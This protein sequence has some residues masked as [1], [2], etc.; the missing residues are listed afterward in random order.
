MN[1]WIA[2]I[3]LV[4]GFIILIRAFGLMEKSKRVF[5]LSA[6]S[7]QAIRNSD[8]SDEKKE[9]ILQKNAVQLFR[10]FFIIAFGGAAAILIPSS[11]VWLCDR[12]GWV[13]FSDVLAITLS[14]LF[15]IIS[16]LFLAVTLIFGLKR[17]HEKVRYSSMERILH[18]LAFNTY[19]AQV[20]LADIEDQL[21]SKK[22]NGC[23]IAKPVFVT[24]LPRAGTTFIL[25]CCAGLPEF[26]SH[27][28]RD[29]PFVLIPCLWNRFSSAFRKSGE[30]QERAHGDGIMINF[31]S[32]EAFE[33]VLWRTFWRRHYLK[34]RI[35]PW[36]DE[37]DPD[38]KAF[39]RSHMRKISL[40]RRED[41]AVHSRYLSKNNMNIARTRIL[42]QLFQDSIILV[43]FRKPLQHA[44]SMVRQHKNFLKIHKEDP[45]A[46]QYMKAIGHY[47]FGKNLRPIDFDG[48]LDKRL[49]EDTGSLAFWLEYWV[50]SYRHLLERS[51]DSLSF[52]NYDGLCENP[53]KGLRTLSDII[54]VQ[55]RNALMDRASRVRA[56]KPHEVDMG[57]IRSS[58]LEEADHIYSRLNKAVIR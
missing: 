6:D 24:A 33:E 30:L 36:N 21:F 4:I 17:S 9:S 10:L 12:L 56:P 26:A 45:F 40:L 55:D 8:L 52:L 2:V 41:D 44:A 51:G 38:F 34:D 11:L 39:F 35:I 53:E 42:R 54:G 37:A 28:Y 58:I 47:D 23:N 3:A 19:P 7:F 25:E 46:S 1:S 5:T 43:P 31:D 27:C 14:P 22:L 57:A 16:G 50:V 48:W 15:L 29:M 13:S 32:P 20:A 49:S 18:N